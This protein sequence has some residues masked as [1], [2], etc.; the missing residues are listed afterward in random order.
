MALSAARIKNLR[1]KSGKSLKVLA[2][3]IG[4]SKAHLWDL[5]TGNSKNPTADVLEKLADTFK[6][7]VASLLE[8]DPNEE[9]D[10]ELVYMFRQLKQLKPEDRELIRLIMEQ[11]KKRERKDGD[12][13]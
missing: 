9:Q 2:D 4:I 12:Q 7:S 3:E 1:M 13:D 5:E 8:E 10:E 6:V 11:K